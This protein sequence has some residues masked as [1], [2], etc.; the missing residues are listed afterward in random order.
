MVVSNLIVAPPSW[1]LLCRLEAGA[2]AEL[3]QHPLLAVEPAAVVRRETLVDLPASDAIHRS[4]LFAGI[5]V[6]SNPVEKGRY[7][8]GVEPGARATP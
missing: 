4:D 6:D 5:T 3:G 1:R 8:F 2:T 7:D